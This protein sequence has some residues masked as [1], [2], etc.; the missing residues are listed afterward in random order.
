MVKTIRLDDDEIHRKLLMIQ[1]K[2]QSETGEYQK[3]DDVIKELIDS[4]NKRKK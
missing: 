4:Y 3:M 1:G 2:M